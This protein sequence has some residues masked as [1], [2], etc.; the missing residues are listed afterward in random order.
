MFSAD[1]QCIAG[2]GTRDGLRASLHHLVLIYSAAQEESEDNRTKRGCIKMKTRNMTS[3]VT[4]IALA[5]AVLA[6]SAYSGTQTYSITDVGTLGGSFSTA[7]GINNN[8]QVVGASSTAGDAAVHAFLYSGGS[9]QDLGTLQ[10]GNWSWANGVNDHGQ[11]VGNAST[12]DNLDHAFLYSG[13]VMQ[14]LGIGEANAINNKGEVVGHSG[15]D[16]AFLY[17]GG[18]MQDLGTLGGIGGGAYGI[19]DSG[20]VV[21]YS[22]T[23]GNSADPH[24]FLYSG[25]SM[26]DLGTLGG[27]FSGARG[28][29][30]SGQVVGES[31]TDNDPLGNGHAFLYSGGSIHDLGTLGGSRSAAWAINNKGQVV[32]FST[33]NRNSGYRAAFLWSDGVM[34]DLNTLL[35]ANSGWYLENAQGINDQGQIVGEGTAPDGQPHAFLLSGGAQPPASPVVAKFGTPLSTD[36]QDGNFLI[37]AL[38]GGL[39]G[40]RSQGNWPAAPGLSLAGSPGPCGP[41]GATGATGP[42]GATGAQGPIGLTGAPGQQ[43]PAGAVGPVGPQGL[44][45]APGVGLVQGTIVFQVEGSTPPEGFTRIGTTVQ[46]IDDPSGKKDRVQLDVYK[47]N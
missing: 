30:N 5:M 41:S 32:G 43:G 21:G 9:M 33:T 17:S 6:G 2:I 35:P 24:A 13:G 38:T 29:N 1:D 18:S 44:Q 28:I 22:F 4:I 39:W 42:A 46:Q 14:D 20:Q 40:P 7:Y 47:R 34:T 15:N 12:S 8:G 26:Q 10:G 31:L 25:G 23:A 11:V 27:S 37:D 3:K 45:G 16:N 36:G 19:N